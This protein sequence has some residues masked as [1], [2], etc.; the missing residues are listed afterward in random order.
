MSMWQRIKDYFNLGKGV[1][2]ERES[3]INEQEAIEEPW[4]VFEV[5]GFEA[6]GRIKVSFNWNQAFITKIYSLGFQAET[7]EDSVQLFFYASQMKPTELASGDSGVGTDAHP[8]LSGQ[9][10]MLRT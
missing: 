2:T 3:Y 6:D 8:Q 5:M 4:A 10:N 7:E 1:K 9:Q